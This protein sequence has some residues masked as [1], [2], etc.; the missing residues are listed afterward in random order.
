MRDGCLICIGKGNKDWN[1]SAPH[2][3]GRVLSRR[4][5]MDSLCMK[6]YR[7]AMEGIYT[8]SISKA[9]LDEA[10]SAYKPIEEIM[11]NIGDTVEIIK[12][13]KPVYNY[14]SPD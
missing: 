7:E 5:A 4:R 14:K 2:G 6:E 9:T 3:A 8:T 13:I 1:Q 12:V 11:E 10:P